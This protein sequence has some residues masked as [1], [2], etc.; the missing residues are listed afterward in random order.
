MA[1]QYVDCCDRMTQF[2]YID[3]SNEAKLRFSKCTFSFSRIF[4]NRRAET[5]ESRSSHSVFFAVFT[6]KSDS[7]GD[8]FSRRYRK[9]KCQTFVATSNPVAGVLCSRISVSAIREAGRNLRHRLH[10]FSRD[11]FVEVCN[12]NTRLVAKYV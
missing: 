5:S 11:F 1:L 6:V 4:S 12:E 3:I 2:R 9:V 8:E 10:V 7:R